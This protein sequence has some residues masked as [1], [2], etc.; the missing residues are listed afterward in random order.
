MNFTDS[1]HR[2][3][4]QQVLRETIHVISGTSKKYRD[5]KGHRRFRQRDK[6]TERGKDRESGKPLT[7]C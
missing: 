6:E 1:I 2:T 4:K 3:E 7:V 5:K